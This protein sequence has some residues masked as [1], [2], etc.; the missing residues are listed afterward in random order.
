MGFSLGSLNPFKSS[1][2]GG[3]VST[4]TTT[5]SETILENDT[6]INS[7][8]D[9]VFN[10]EEIAKVFKERLDF[11]IEQALKEND[12]EFTEEQKIKIREIA[13]QEEALKLN[14]QNA[15][16]NTY[17]MLATVV[18]VVFLIWKYLKEENKKKGAK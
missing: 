14:Q 17:V 1:G 9:V 5:K 7:D 18:S 15:R 6:T 13:I 10:F 11:D 2:G 8:V 3:S 4:Q 16:N 12:G